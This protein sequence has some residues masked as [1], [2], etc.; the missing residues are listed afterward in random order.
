M[1]LPHAVL[2]LLSFQPTTGY[3]LAQRFDKSLSNAWHASHSQIYP[4]LARLQGDGMVEVV[5]EGA[6]GSKTYAVTDAGHEEL[7]R[8]LL[9]TPPVRTQRNETAVRW[10]LLFLLPPDQRRVVLERELAEVEGRAGEYREIA[11]AI[12]A[13][14][15]GSPFRPTL[16]LGARTSKVMAD[17]LREQ[18]AALGRASPPGRR[19]RR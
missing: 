2:G 7:R 14:P 19:G 12:D 5:G 3:D 18:L 11:A 4:A 10:F 15:Q 17:W 9:E 8:W 16:D 13:T 6:R 1:S